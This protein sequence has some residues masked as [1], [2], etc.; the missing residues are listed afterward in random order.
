MAEAM[1]RIDHMEAS[2]LRVKHEELLQNVLGRLQV[3]HDDIV[4]VESGA[5]DVAE[6]HLEQKKLAAHVR[7][8]HCSLRVLNSRLRRAVTLSPWQVHGCSSCFS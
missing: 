6:Q 3:M 8:P 7:R 2:L 5:V 4:D 1:M